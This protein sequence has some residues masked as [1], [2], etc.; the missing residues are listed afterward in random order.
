MFPA[1]IGYE[2]KASV[3]EPFWV[4]DKYYM[5]IGMVTNNWRAGQRVSQGGDGV[6]GWGGVEERGKSKCLVTSKYLKGLSH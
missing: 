6:R 5:W 1:V 4:L 2:E 3:Q